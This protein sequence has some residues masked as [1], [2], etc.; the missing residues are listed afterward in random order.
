MAGKLCRG[1]IWTPG[2]KLARHGGECCGA[3]RITRAISSGGASSVPKE[4]RTYSG[5]AHQYDRCASFVAH[6]AFHQSSLGHGTVTWKSGTSECI[7]I[8]AKGSRT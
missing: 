6:P 1:K 3:G 5:N 2:K 4:E 8:V 7:S